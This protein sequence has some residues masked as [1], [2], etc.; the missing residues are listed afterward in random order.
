MKSGD[1]RASMPIEGRDR[2]SWCKRCRNICFRMHLR[3]KSYLSSMHG[4]FV[5]HL[6]QLACVLLHDLSCHFVFLF[7]SGFIAFRVN[8]F[9]LWTLPQRLICCRKLVIMFIT[10]KDQ[11]LVEVIPQVVLN[12]KDPVRSTGI[13]IGLLHLHALVI[14]RPEPS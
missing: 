14:L 8:F 10:I 3:M 12:A 11:Q 6:L 9:P 2:S 1:S 5:L 4:A 13:L 7:S